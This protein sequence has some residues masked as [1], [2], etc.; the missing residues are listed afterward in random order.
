MKLENKTELEQP[1][2]IRNTPNE[3]SDNGWRIIGGVKKWIR[4]CKCGNEVLHLSKP[5]R[6]KAVKNKSRCKVCY[7]DRCKEQDKENCRI[8]NGHKMWI[9][10]CPTC[11]RETTYSVKHN[12]KQK[13]LCISCA[14]KGDKNY[15]FGKIGP[16][17]GSTWTD[18]QTNKQIK[19]M[20]G[21][22]NPNFGKVGYWTGCSF[23][24]THRLN[25][26]KSTRIYSNDQKYSCEKQRSHFR[27]WLR[28]CCRF[29]KYV[30]LS[31]REFKIWIILK[32][33]DGMMWSN[34]GRHT[35]HIDH[36][37]PL[38]KFDLTNK[39]E[40]KKAWNYTNLQPLSAFDN[41]SKGHKI[42]C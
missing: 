33:K 38:C 5:D 29:E 35:W 13:K 10:N 14:H 7:Q 17:Q 26:S 34:H 9:G 11:K 21:R 15:W 19:R 40:A 37:I 42:L 18:E 28:G 1:D 4:I 16:R 41:L 30:G 3:L 32:F 8:I 23:S 27:S 6:N 24:E 36:K 22:N 2:I 20:S 12:W 31:L 25:L 39:E